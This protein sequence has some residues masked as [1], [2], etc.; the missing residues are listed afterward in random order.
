MAVKMWVISNYYPKIEDGVEIKTN[1]I[2]EWT[3]M[4]VPDFKVRYISMINLTLGAIFT[5]FVYPEREK[6]ISRLLLE[7]FNNNI[8]F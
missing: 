7:E 2:F 6:L 1:P 5:N 8:N 4:E 3:C